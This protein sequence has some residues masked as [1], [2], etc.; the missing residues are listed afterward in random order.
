MLSMKSLSM[1]AFGAILCTT[2]SSAGVARDLDLRMTLTIDDRDVGTVRNGRDVRRALARCNPPRT[3]RYV[4]L[5]RDPQINYAAEFERGGFSIVHRSGP[6]GPLWDAKRRV[7][8]NLRQF[9]TREMIRI[10]ADYIDGKRSPFVR[11]KSK[12]LFSE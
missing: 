6:P 10:T 3:C 8:G 2:A 12:S 11:W 1:C 5:E 9:S 7:R 4:G